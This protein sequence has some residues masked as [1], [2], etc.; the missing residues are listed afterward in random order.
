MEWK[1]IHSLLGKR[2]RH[3]LIR[4]KLTLLMLIFFVVQ[5]TAGI[6]AQQI[7]LSVNQ[8]PL[9]EVMSEIRKQSGYNFV[10]RPNAKTKAK[11]VSV[12]LAGKDLK[13]AL[14]LIFKTQD[15]NYDIA[16]KSII[17]SVR[18]VSP[19][20]PHYE[21]AIDVTEVKQEP[22]RGQVLTEK[23]EPIQGVTVAVKG[24][25]RGVLTDEHGRYEINANKGEQLLFSY[26]G[27]TAQTI[28][29]EDSEINVTMISG[30]DLDEV[31]VVG[32][33]TQRKGNL[34]GAVDQIG[35]EYFQDRPVP[36][37]GRALQGVIPNLNIDMTD[38]K[39]IRNPTYN[40]RGVTTIGPG[41]NSLVLID[42]VPGDP[43]FLNSQD[44]ES[45]TVLKDA[46]A[47]AIYGARGAFGV[48]LITTKSPSKSKTQINYS[49]DYSINQRTTTPDW[50]WDGYTWAKMFNESYSSWYDY[51]STPT[52]VYNNFP[53]SLD[54]LDALRLRAENP[55][56]YPEIEIDPATGNYV[57]YGNTNWLKELY[58][59]A[60]PSTQH[61]LSISGA[62]NKVD[63][64]LS[65]KYY[66]QDGIFKYNTDTYDQYNI[67]MKG[68]IQVTDWLKISNNTDY[69]NYQYY[70]P[71]TANHLYDMWTNVKLRGFPMA[72]MFNPDGTLTRNAAY[73]VGEFYYGK[74]NSATN[75]SLLMNTVS[76]SAKFLEN[77]L[78]VNGNFT[79]RNIRREIINKRVPVPFSEKPGE[80][81]VE[82]TSSLL[83]DNQ[84]QNYLASNI[85]ADYSHDIGDH[86]FKVMAG[87]NV[88]S[89]RLRNQRS[90]RDLL[91]LEDLTDFNLAVGQNYLI[92]GGGS[93]WATSGFFSRINYGYKNK[94]LV[95]LNGRYDGSSKF[96]ENERYALFPSMSAGWVVSEE[97]FVK[98]NVS[99]LDQLKLRASYGTLGNGQLP[100]YTYQQVIRPQTSGNIVNGAFPIYIR[101]PG[102]LPDDLTWEKST[103]TNFG[104]DLTVLNNRLSMN[105]DLFKRETTDMIRAGQPLPGIFGAA[106]PRSNNANLETKGWELTLKW[107][108]RTNWEKPLRYDFRFTLSD[109]E[110][111]ITKFYNPTG[112]LATY[113][114]GRKFG[115]LWGYVTDG[116]FL[117]EEEILNHAD[118]SRIVVSSGNMLLPG[119]LK[120]KDLNGDWFINN[121]RNTIDDHGDLTIVGNTEA[122]Y[123]YGFTTNLQWSNFSLSAF[124]QGVGMRDWWPSHESGIFW[125]HYT[126]WY[127]V[128]PR[129]TLDGTWTL[130]DP[131]P[132]SYFPRYRGPMTAAG[133]ELGVVQTRYLQDVSYIRLKNLTVGYSLPQQWAH[134]IKSQS[135]R[136]YV[137][138]QNLWTYSPMYKLTK[139]I[140]PEVIEGSDPEIRS[141]MGDGARYPM[142][143]SYTFGVNVVF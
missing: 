14:D 108:D 91:L 16:G 60:H 79:Y 102:E 46:A 89:D 112:S 111:Y 23:G 50:V 134:R 9:E 69:S 119:D 20:Q 41:G 137:T 73:S 95:E 22:V 17:L 61:S 37:I 48:V 90:Q 31:I 38:G 63:Y 53:F 21:T 129:H 12:S 66:R 8:A 88:E 127:G 94:Y 52:T 104:V 10:F 29:V 4:M 47:S 5:T 138:G 98:D 101:E 132:D 19:S 18:K 135:I 122:R 68:G 130:D 133:R 82:G 106:V 92:T 70:Y 74:S 113:Y 80:I 96:P 2:F 55:G 54:Y 110:T 107:A 100:P 11:K 33:G 78:N 65:S 77:K 40:V 72:M 45:V 126:R 39:P 93:E 84:N 87:W 13:E 44:I 99:W 57:Y 121:G 1:V 120:F 58:T 115:E 59:D 28:V 123:R 75:R 139:D 109:S 62:E 116:L 114:E 36:N 27:Y 64:S 83:A 105:F 85:Y 143:K 124:F 25:T 140:D 42:G 142:L 34:T 7:T 141:D 71:I 43:I 136:M 26:V 24:S 35:S 30:K 56:E 76:F 81:I 51:V 15:L 49:G 128:L 125:G 118:Q 131:N 103:T 86:H 32:Y 3:N 117:S 97:N 6:R 67:R